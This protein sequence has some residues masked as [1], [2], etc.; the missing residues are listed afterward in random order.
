MTNQF[1][2]WSHTYFG[3]PSYIVFLQR[4]HVILPRKH[5]RLHHVVPHDTYFCITT[6]WLNW[7][8]EMI[9]FWPWLESIVETYTGA[10]P[11]S[12]DFAWAQKTEKVHCY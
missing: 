11:R 7:P 3:L 9:K 4:Y 1:H 12:D 10:K 5:H 2:K 6:G 8:L